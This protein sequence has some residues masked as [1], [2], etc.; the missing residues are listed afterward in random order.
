MAYAHVG[1]R[2]ETML[3]LHILSVEALMLWF[4]M[5]KLMHA[6]LALPSRYQIGVAYERK[7]V[8]A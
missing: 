2:Y 1:L 4:P 5:G 7:G 3:A 8:R 6:F